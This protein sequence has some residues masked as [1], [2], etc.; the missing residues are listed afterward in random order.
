MFRVSCRRMKLKL[1]C[2]VIYNNQGM[3]K[4]ANR[5]IRRGGT[6][7]CR[8]KRRRP[9][10]KWGSDIWPQEAVEAWKGAERNSKSNSYTYNHN[11]GKKEAAA[12]AHSPTRPAR[13]EWRCGLKM[14]SY[15]AS[16]YNAKRFASL[17]SSRKRGLRTEYCRLVSR[18]PSAQQTQGALFSALPYSASER[19]KR[20]LEFTIF[21]PSSTRMAT[22]Q[23]QKE[24]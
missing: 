13:S 12:A 2:G 8:K 20:D 18:V 19:E 7:T 11:R 15:F 9:T 24:W 4:N 5:H 21:L 23:L 16:A 10:S 17:I 14:S 6:R 3:S 22:V 1:F